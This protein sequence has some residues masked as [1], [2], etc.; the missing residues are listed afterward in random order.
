MIAIKKNLA[1]GKIEWSYTKNKFKKWKL[2]WGGK[3]TIVIDEVQNVKLSYLMIRKK[4]LYSLYAG[5]ILFFIVVAL[6]LFFDYGI[7]IPRLF[8]TMTISILEY[9]LYLFFVGHQRRPSSINSKK[10]IKNIKIE[11]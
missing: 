4:V 2:W 9:I 6:L 1:V 5:L 3:K 7:S 11:K 8:L 10:A